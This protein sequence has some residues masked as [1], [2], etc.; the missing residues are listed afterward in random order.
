MLESSV[1][2]SAGGTENR[3]GHSNFMASNPR[4]TQHAMS[5]R[6]TCGSQCRT[7]IPPLYGPLT[8][9]I[10]STVGALFCNL[11]VTLPVLNKMCDPARSRNVIGGAASF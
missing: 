10:P 7:E 9:L 3:S 6:V 1:P 2:G 8:C 11:C 4:S 5:P